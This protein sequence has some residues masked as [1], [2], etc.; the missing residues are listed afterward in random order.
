[1]TNQWLSL[2]RIVYTLLMKRHFRKWGKGSYLWFPARL[3]NPHLI[4][5]GIGVVICEHAWLTAKDKRADGRSTLTIGDGTYVGRFTQIN[6]W[7]DV[8]IETNVLIADRVYI[9][10]A[11]HLYNDP[12]LPISLQ[13][14][15][16]AGAVRLCSGCWIGI[17]AV[18]MP[19]VS[20]GENAVV[21]ANAVVTRDVPAH[22]I[23]GGVPARIIEKVD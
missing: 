16:F 9:S 21:G 10:D 18:I 17:G 2:V 7:H 14:D 8:V 23:A 3:H 12:N 11:D 4:E 20:V 13:G 19:G 1:M 15:K 22:T 5:V 6:A